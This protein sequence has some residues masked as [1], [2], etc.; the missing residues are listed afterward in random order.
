MSEHLSE[1]SFVKDVEDED[2]KTRNLMEEISE[3]SKKEFVFLMNK[4]KV[5]GKDRERI[6]LVTNQMK[7]ME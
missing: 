4:Y 7:L 1:F 5:N 2:A 6:F 3:D